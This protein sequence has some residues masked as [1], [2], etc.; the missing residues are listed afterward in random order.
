MNELRIAI[1][2]LR[3]TPGFTITAV[4][5]LAL[6]IGATT[7]SSASSMRFCFGHSPYHDPNRLVVV[8]LSLPDY[9]D[10]ARASRSFEQTA[11][12][13]TNQYN[14][15][16]GDEPSGSRRR[17]LARPAPAA[18]RDAGVRTQFHD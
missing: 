15:R 16:T 14:V 3:R 6:G 4:L 17:D 7:P 5:T 1:R 12:W 11:V 9:Q 18:R 2:R 8:R 13:A 10:A